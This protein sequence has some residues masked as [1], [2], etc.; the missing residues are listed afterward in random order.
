M[1]TLPFFTLYPHLFLFFT[2]CSCFHSLHLFTFPFFTFYPHSHSLHFIHIPILIMFTF[3]HIPNFSLLCYRILETLANGKE[4]VGSV[5]DLVPRKD[6]SPISSLRLN[7]AFALALGTFLFHLLHTYGPLL[8]M[9][10]LVTYSF[11][12]VFIA[13]YTLP[14]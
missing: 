2:F 12:G 1:F 3:L 7:L 5:E 8:W 13:F 6:F 14:F 9:G 4:A 11:L 10:T